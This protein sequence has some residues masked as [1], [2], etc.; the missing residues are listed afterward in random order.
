MF[1]HHKNNAVKLSLAN[2]TVDNCSINSLGT[3]SER[4]NSGGIFGAIKIQSW[5]NN[6]YFLDIHDVIVKNTA[7][8]S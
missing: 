7:I 2:L 4:A 5:T 3:N 1:Y 6:D 8:I